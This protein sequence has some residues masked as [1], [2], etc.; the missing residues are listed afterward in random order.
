MERLQ[1]E[2]TLNLTLKEAID[3]HQAGNLEHARDQSKANRR[4]T[5]PWYFL[6]INAR[7]PIYDLELFKQATMIRPDISQ[8]W[9]S[10]LGA[11]I[12]TQTVGLVGESFLDPKPQMTHEAVVSKTVESIN[13]AAWQANTQEY[14]MDS[15][16][17]CYSTD[18][19]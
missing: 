15:I 7:Y 10:Y 6:P 13:E 9:F 19:F 8:Y 14:L 3:A 11:L 12:D 5:Q 1:A 4:N 17:N 18:A 16:R 2:A